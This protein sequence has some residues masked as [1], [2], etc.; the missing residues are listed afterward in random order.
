M[1]LEVKIHEKT[2]KKRSGNALLMDFDYILIV[3]LEAK[4]SK[5]Q[6]QNG[7]KDGM[8]LGIDFFPL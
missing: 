7:V 6:S 4:A 8:H 5:N 1:L 3:I 2:I